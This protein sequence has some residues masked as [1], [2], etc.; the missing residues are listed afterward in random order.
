[1]I[2]L[3]PLFYQP[4][5]HKLS[6]FFYPDQQAAVRLLSQDTSALNSDRHSPSI[7]GYNLRHLKQESPKKRLPE[8]LF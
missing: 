6:Q 1:M 5:S 8:W 2:S 3:N 7:A 4:F